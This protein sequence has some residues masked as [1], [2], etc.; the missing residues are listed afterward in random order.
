LKHDQFIFLEGLAVEVASLLAAVK[1]YLAQREDNL[2]NE[3]EILWVEK[4]ICRLT[5]LVKILMVNI[6]GQLSKH[7][8]TPKPS[9]P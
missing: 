8:F 9:N 6:A 5:G 2:G 7:S 1:A 4:V 3:W